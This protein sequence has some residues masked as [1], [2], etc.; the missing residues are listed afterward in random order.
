MSSFGPWATQ[1]FFTVDFRKVGGVT[2]IIVGPSD[3]QSGVRDPHKLRSFL[4]DGLR[5]AL[6]VSLENFKVEEVPVTPSTRQ[7]ARYGSIKEGFRKQST[8]PNLLLASKQRE[9]VL[10]NPLPRT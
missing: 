1:A 2:H 10:D 8:V 4:M 7:L 5:Y 6:S 9:G 3:E